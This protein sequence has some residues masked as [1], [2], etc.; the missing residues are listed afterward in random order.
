MIK[1][2]NEIVHIEKNS[3]Y[4]KFNEEKNRDLYPQYKYLIWWM[5]D[6]G[7]RVI[8][9]D[10]TKIYNNLREKHSYTYLQ[11]DTKLERFRCN[12]IL[13]NDEHSRIGVL[14][15]KDHPE[16]QTERKIFQNV[17][18]IGYTVKDTA[19]GR[20]KWEMFQPDEQNF[21]FYITKAGIL[22]LTSM[23]D[24]FFFVGIKGVDGN[25]KWRIEDRKKDSMDRM[26]KEREDFKWLKLIHEGLSDEELRIIAKSMFMSNVDNKD[27]EQVRDWIIND[28]IRK[29]NKIVSNSG[30]NL[31]MSLIEKTGVDYD[32]S[33]TINSAL[34]DGFLMY[35]LN[36]KAWWFIKDG[37]LVEEFCKLNSKDPEKL[38]NFLLKTPILYKKLLNFYND[39]NKKLDI[40]ITPNDNNISPNIFEKDNQKRKK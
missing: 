6:F 36:E 37:E 11:G 25:A 1:R 19:E 29:M 34:D 35:K 17:P 22:T 9:E 30:T 14:S 15:V 27:I 39:N 2:N 31:F 38:Y 16:R 33:M 18:F 32:I 4:K 13:D 28:K 23:E 8:D 21:V 10:Y 26:I 12:I 7:E 24:I 3:N 5:N 40:N 20:I